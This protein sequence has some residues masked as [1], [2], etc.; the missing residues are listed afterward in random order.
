[1]LRRREGFGVPPLG[2]QIEHNIGRIDG[3]EQLF[4]CL[5]FQLVEIAGVTADAR[6]LV[7]VQRDGQSDFSL[8]DK[9][10]IPAQMALMA[11]PESQRAPSLSQRHA[12]LGN[13]DLDILCAALADV[14]RIGE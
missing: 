8:A 6:R 7:A 1:M 13:L 3:S 5:L 12:G 10:Q 11:Q 4:G 2:P 9:A 14:P